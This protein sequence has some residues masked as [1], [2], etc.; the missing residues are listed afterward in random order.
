MSGPVHIDTPAS[1]KS[2]CGLPFKADDAPNLVPKF[3]FGSKLPVN[4]GGEDSK[5]NQHRS[6]IALTLSP[7]LTPPSKIKS[8]KNETIKSQSKEDVKQDDGTKNVGNEEVK[9]DNEKKNVDAM[10]A[11]DEHGT[12]YNDVI[13]RIEEMDAAEFKDSSEYESVNLSAVEIP[14]YFIS[15]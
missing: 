4:L 5:F 8:S 7:T 2:A 10:P 14:D 13:R 15:S 6:N 12:T 9:Q 3:S 1:T 11:L